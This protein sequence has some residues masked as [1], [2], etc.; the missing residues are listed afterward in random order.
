M[1][2]FFSSKHICGHDSLAC[3]W[4]W[5][6]PLFFLEK[7]C[8]C[9]LVVRGHP[10]YLYGEFRGSRRGCGYPTR[11]ASTCSCVFIHSTSPLYVMPKY[12]DS[13]NPWPEKLTNVLNIIHTHAS[14]PNPTFTCRFWMAPLV[15]V[16]TKDEYIPLPFWLSKCLKMI[17]L[18]FMANLVFL[19]PSGPWSHFSLINEPHI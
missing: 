12:L 2:F 18:H 3:V 4:L 6:P 16:H 9:L 1:F 7:Y 14:H 5:G 19:L 11:P 10:H 8:G 15:L 17:S 13:D